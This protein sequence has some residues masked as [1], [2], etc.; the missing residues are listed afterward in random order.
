MGIAA[1]LAVGFISRQVKLLVKRISTALNAQSTLA[2]GL[3]VVEAWPMQ[4]ALIPLSYLLEE[5][6]SK[7][8]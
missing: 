8:N 3:S 6:Y 1:A 7:E 5:N 2:R 4:S